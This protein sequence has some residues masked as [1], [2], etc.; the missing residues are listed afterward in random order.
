MWTGAA[1]G[2]TPTIR[3]TTANDRRHSTLTVLKRDSISWRRPGR[4]PD[5]YG[6]CRDVWH[7]FVICPTGVRLV[8]YGAGAFRSSHRSPVS[9][10]EVL[11]N[12]RLLKRRKTC[13]ATYQPGPS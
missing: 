3:T 1:I 9:G 7:G 4:D 11:A 13:R 8:A 12:S 2:S 6:N 5:A 10:T